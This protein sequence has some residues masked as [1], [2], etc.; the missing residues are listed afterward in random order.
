MSSG[1]G[2]GWQ[3]SDLSVKPASWQ[4]GAGDREALLF[5]GNEPI[6]SATATISRLDSGAVI[7]DAVESVTVASPDVTIMV[8]GLTAGMT[9]MLKLTITWA[10][11]S[12]QSYTLIIPCPA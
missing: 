7:P 5:V 8:T 12:R 1:F 2:F 10:S 4:I 3:A 11:G 6:A 9:Y